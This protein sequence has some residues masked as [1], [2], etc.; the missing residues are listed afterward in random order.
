KLYAEAAAATR[1]YEA[2]QRQAARQRSEAQRLEKLLD[3]ERREISVLR[4]DLGRL[5]RSQYRNGGGLPLTAHMILA[6]DPDE[7]MRGQRV[8][9]QANLALD[10]AL[11]K[12]ARAEAR[13]ARDEAKAAAAW[14]K[15]EKRN[16]QLADL[17]RDIEQKLE[18]A[19]WQL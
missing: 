1:R 12:S 4:E 5:A 10:N 14:K 13:L 3:R 18:T 2:G 9:S 16:R 15:L 6:D 8:F 17:K 7:L 11:E 19:R